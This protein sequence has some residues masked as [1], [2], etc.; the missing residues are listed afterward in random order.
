MTILQAL[1][2]YYHRLDGV[3]EPGQSP[4]KFGWCIVL[5]RDGA[6]IDVENLHD[7]SG[8]KPRPKTY[9]VPAAVKRTVGIAPNFLWDKS[10]YVL[11]RT[12]G[13]GKRTAQEHAAFVASH[14]ERLA[15]QTD[16]CLVALRRFLETWLPEYFDGNGKFTRSEEH[17]SELQSLMRISYAVFCLKKK[18]K[19][20][21]T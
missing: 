6:V 4:E 17:T 5:G 15:D 3:A 11:G 14:L 13:E 7:L 10:A 16:E 21:T 12:A 19:R 2:S 20:N 8:K 1:D 18:K 9:M